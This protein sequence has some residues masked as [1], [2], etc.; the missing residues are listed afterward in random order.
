MLLKTAATIA[1]GRCK[2]SARGGQVDQHAAG[3][4]GVYLY[5]LHDSIA[6]VVEK[7]HELAELVSQSEIG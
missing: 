4:A 2:I 6:D 3:N 5:S 7:S 1:V